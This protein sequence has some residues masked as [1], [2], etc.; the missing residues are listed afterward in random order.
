MEETNHYSL[1]PNNKENYYFASYLY[2]IWLQHGD[3]KPIAIFQIQIQKIR[4]SNGDET[5]ITK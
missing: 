5:T 1:I 4:K 2:K 3:Y